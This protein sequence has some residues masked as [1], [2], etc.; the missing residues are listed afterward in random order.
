MWIPK[1]PPKFPVIDLRNICRGLGEVETRVSLVDS[2]GRAQENWLHLGE[3]SVQKRGD[4]RGFPKWVLQARINATDFEH[5]SAYVCVLPLVGVAFE[6]CYNHGV[7]LH[8]IIDTSE[9]I[10][11]PQDGTYDPAKMKGSYKCEQCKGKQAHRVVPE[12]F[13]QPPFQLKLQEELRGQAVEIFIG[14]A[15]SDKE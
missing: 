10:R 11:V 14:P 8:A 5:D 6:A 3:A 4:N 15:R 12:G 2:V 1:D 7:L 13:Y 9:E